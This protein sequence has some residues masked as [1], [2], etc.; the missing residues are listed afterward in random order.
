MTKV[1]KKCTVLYCRHEH[2]DRERE[3][4]RLVSKVSFTVVDPEHGT[5]IR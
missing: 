4:V 3:R 2:V 1:L 5:Y